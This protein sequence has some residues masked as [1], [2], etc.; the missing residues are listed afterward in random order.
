MSFRYD[1]IYIICHKL[2]FCY[3]LFC[4]VLFCSVYPREAQPRSLCMNISQYIYDIP[5]AICHQSDPCRCVLCVFNLYFSV[6][7]CHT[8]IYVS[9]M[10]LYLSGLFVVLTQVSFVPPS[11]PTLRIFG[12]AALQRIKRT[13]L[14]NVHVIRVTLG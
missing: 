10:Y 11:P 12:H 6:R 14:T 2:L 3:V 5:F 7:V 1:S 13:D 4:S 9:Y 8:I